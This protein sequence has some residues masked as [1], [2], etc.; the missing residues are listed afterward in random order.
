[1]IGTDSF[2]YWIGLCVLSGGLLLGN[3]LAG[4]VAIEPVR[5]P[6]DEQGEHDE[7]KRANHFFADFANLCVLAYEV[8]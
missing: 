8:L 2:L 1:M 3:L 7:E 6:A 4:E 5:G